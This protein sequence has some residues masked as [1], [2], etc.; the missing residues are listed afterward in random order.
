MMVHRLEVHPN[1][2]KFCKDQTNC[3]FTKC[4]FKHSKERNVNIVNE[5]TAASEEA[6]N[7]DFQNAPTS[8]KPPLNKQN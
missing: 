6:M 8:L 5:N 1:K 2:V 7:Q 4:W 3:T